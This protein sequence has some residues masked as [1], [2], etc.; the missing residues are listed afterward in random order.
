MNKVIKTIKMTLGILKQDKIVLLLSLIP[1]LIGFVLFYFLGNYLYTD[2]LDM[3]KAYIEQN[4]QSSGWASAFY[5]LI[6]GILTVTFFFLIN[7]GFVLVVSLI[8]SPFNDLISHRVEKI[9]LGKE[10][11]GL[12]VAFERI[13]G[14]F[15]FTIV[16]EF[17]KILFIIFLTT[18]SFA[19]G[20]VPLVGPILSTV[21]AAYLISIQFLDYNW[22]RHDLT[23]RQCLKDLKSTPF[24]YLLSGLIFIFLLS[25]P[26][27]NL[28][29]LP[30][31]VIYYAIMFSDKNS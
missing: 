6:A 26:I 11:S 12:G 23:M 29:S 7:W 20:L 21:M 9:V 16:N 5:Y 25:I 19:L 22:S 8:A 1:V 18:I 17:K 14:K 2:L 13:I 31:A 4:I 10:L 24:V 27:V 15:F 30:F 28:I 3:G